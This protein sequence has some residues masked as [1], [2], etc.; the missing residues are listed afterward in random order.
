MSL[1]FHKNHRLLLNVVFSGFVVLTLII[2]IG[3]A[4]WVQDHNE[5]LPGSQPLTQQQQRGLDIYVAEG[6]LYCHTQ[7]VRPLDLDKPFGRPSAPGDYARLRPQDIWRMTP[8]MLGTERNGP[9]LSDVGSRQSSDAWNYIHLYNPRSVVEASVMQA[10]PWLFAVK[11]SPGPDDVVVP[12]P[13]EFAPKK[14][15]VVATE[16]ARDL[17]AYL[18]SLKQVPVPGTEKGGARAPSPGGP[19]G[20]ASKG[21]SL[22]SSHCASCHQINGEGVPG[23]FP[24]LKGNPA[25]TAKDPTHH[26]EVVLTGLQGRTINGVKYAAAMPSFEHSLSDADIAAVVNHERTSWGNN[27]PTVT[28]ADVSAI[29]E[30]EEKEEKGGHH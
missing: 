16:K 20:E 25:V 7:Q 14:G 27:A 9:D 1:N 8:E 11:D 23:T 26:I 21:A 22:Y 19:R 17:V 12:V 5:P 3:P 4:I 28:A 15:K 13:S 10:Y 18:L 6:C 2:A 29:R 30:K 24:P